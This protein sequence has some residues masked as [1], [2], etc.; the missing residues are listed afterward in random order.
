VPGDGAAAGRGLLGAEHPGDRENDPLSTVRRLQALVFVAALAGLGVSAYLTVVHYTSVP[1]VCTTSGAI[2]C[3]QVLSSPYAVIAGTT[4][5]TSAA[6][7]LWFTVTAVAAA[8]RWA[9]ST[10]H[11]VA[12]LQLAWS[13]IGLVTVVGLV[14]IEIVA[15]GAIC[16]WCSAAHVLVIAIF[17][18]SLASAERSNQ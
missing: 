13:A 6:G 14:F 11:V 10:S 3:E 8:M 5:P 17:L 4:L 7:I 1:L 2:N 9:S 16:I 12:R 15:L 18:L